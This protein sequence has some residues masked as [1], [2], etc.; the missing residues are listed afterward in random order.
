MSK[1][2]NIECTV[3]AGPCSIDEVNIKEV[4]QIAEMEVKNSK[5]TV[6]RAVAGTRVVGLKSRTELDD[7]G[8]G[9]GMD[10]RVVQK[11]IDI[12]A[13]GGCAS[14]FEIAPSAYMAEEVNK[15]TNM[16]IATEVMM[17]SVQLPSFE[18]KLPK[19]KL[20]PWNPSVNQLGWQIHE[21]ARFAKRNNWHVGIKNGKWVGEAVHVANSVHFTG[22]TTMEK[23]W[24]GLA[25]YA[26]KL[27]GDT[28]L[29]HRGVD[30]PD[31]GNYR[32][33]PVH[34]IAMRTKTTTGLKLY[35]DPSHALGPKMRNEIVSATIEAMKLKLSAGDYVYD[36]ILV[37]VG[38]SVTDTLQHITLKEL[39]YM[40]QELAKFRD[41]T[42][43]AKV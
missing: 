31:K 28:I 41:L 20:M 23:T 2:K 30:V 6:Q 16:L 33:F 32:S 15:K 34:Q 1:P 27:V 19:G 38:T 11:N 10:Y 24:S 12:I 22:K 36:G 40:L 4:F 9:M 39:K 14:D 8:K 35:F 3:V 37:E 43:P 18:Q 7:T 17:P 29:I 21:M 42:P 26:G 5:G 25:S 13:E